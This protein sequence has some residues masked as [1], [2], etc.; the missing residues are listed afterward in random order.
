MGQALSWDIFKMPPKTH[1][2]WSIKNVS[3]F[4]HNKQIKEIPWTFLFAFKHHKI[5]KAYTKNLILWLKF[6][7]SPWQASKN[8]NSI[9]HRLYKTRRK[10]ICKS[11]NSEM[12]KQ[13]SEISRLAKWL[14]TFYTIFNNF[15]K[16]LYIFE[17]F[18]M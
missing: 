10:K 9:F 16:F 5:F 6:L 12:W 4:R 3:T 14:S 18:S 13:F 17:E 7:I 2:N 11:I 1:K 15:L 8:F